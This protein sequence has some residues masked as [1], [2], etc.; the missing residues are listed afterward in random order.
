MTWAAI[1]VLLAPDR[2]D[3]QKPVVL[4]PILQG[5]ALQLVFDRGGV[6]SFDQNNS[7]FSEGKT[8]LRTF[9]AS[10]VGYVSRVIAG[11]NELRCETTAAVS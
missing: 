11:W 3:A 4:G 9:W 8:K 5:S 2:G 1:I 10:A 6:G 7:F